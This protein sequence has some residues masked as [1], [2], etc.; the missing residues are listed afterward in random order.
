[1]HG[2]S[3]QTVTW[4]V[5]GNVGGNSAVGFID[6]ISGLYTAPPSP[7][8]VTVHASSNVVSPAAVGS[9]SV[10]VVNPQPPPP[11]PPVISVSI[12]PTSASVRLKNTR[13]FTA[14]V[15]N[16]TNTAVTWT[17]NNILGGNATLGTISTSGLYRAPTTAPLPLKVTVKATSSADPS[18]SASA[19]VTI[20]RK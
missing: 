18:K 14:T 3:L 4:D 16:T 1:M 7:V 6:S 15:T 13:Q 20:T 5:N 17:V 10:T 19:A 12:S 8:N 9:A 11:P 2:N